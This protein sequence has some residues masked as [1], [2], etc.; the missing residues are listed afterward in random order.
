MTFNLMPLRAEL[1]TLKAFATLTLA[2]L[3]L[4][5]EVFLAE[6][7]KKF[8]SKIE[9]ISEMRQSQP[10]IIIYKQRRALVK[11]LGFGFWGCEKS[12]EGFSVTLR[13]FFGFSWLTCHI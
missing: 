2:L 5:K 3:P 8:S 6:E 11:H 13:N 10:T 12:F 1:P 9:M 4:L 7:Q